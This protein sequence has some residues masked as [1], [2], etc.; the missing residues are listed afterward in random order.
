MFS[1]AMIAPG[2]NARAEIYDRTDEK[3]KILFSKKPKLY[4]IAIGK[5]DFLYQANADFRKKL[6]DNGYTYKY[7][8]TPEGHILKNWRIYWSEFAPMLF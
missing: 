3:L 5:D 2:E 8:E 7:F 1:A 4:Y 6:D